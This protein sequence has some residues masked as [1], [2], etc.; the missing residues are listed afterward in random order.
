M[1]LTLTNKIK[2][3]NLSPDELSYLVAECHHTNPAYGE[4][5]KHG[6]SVRNIDKTIDLSSWQ[7]GALTVPIGL[8][9]RV[10]D[11]YPDAKVADQRATHPVNIPFIGKLRP[12]QAQFIQ[13]A[14]QQGGGVMVAATGAG[15]SISG[16]A[17][18]A[19]LGERCLIL[20]K[21]KDLAQ[22]WIEAIEQ[23]TG[24]R[25]GLIGDGK[26]SE[27][28]H[29]TI[30]LTQTLSKRDLSLLDYGLV[31][32]DEAH[33][34]PASQAYRVINGI[35]A[36][37]K[38]GL[39]ATPQRRDNLEFMIFGALGGVC[40]EIKADELDGKVLPVKVMIQNV[41]F[42]GIAD[43]WQ[44]FQTALVNDEARNRFLINRAATSS[45]RQ[46][47]IILCA[48]VGHC[49]VLGVMA[50]ELGVNALVLHGQLPAKE[51][52]ER[53]ANAPHAPLIIGTLSLLSE[54][55]DLPHLTVLIF[56]SPVSAEVDREN[57]AA[58]RL[59]QSIG[60]CRRPYPNK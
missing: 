52:A 50:H 29:F 55:I 3:T 48:Q 56:A 39:S 30:G 22:Q 27:G 49:E 28:E 44:S 2:I 21:S 31:I 41:A 23:F 12:Y 9:G 19:E 40:A 17:L 15:K 8:L 6:R 54:G 42:T 37:Y 33:N 36:R 51:R 43:S 34:L 20:V 58:T 32:A 59:L 46:G 38:F 53:M 4:A 10:I 26:D 16:I 13:D 14:M 7:D 47:T 60:R 57:P 5:L 1:N 45:M 24:L 18:A 35:N 11:L 25:A